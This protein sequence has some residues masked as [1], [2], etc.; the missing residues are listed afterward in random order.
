MG[1]TPSMKGTNQMVF[2]GRRP[3]EAG[4]S[5]SGE[6]GETQRARDAIGARRER[7]AG[8]ADDAAPQRAACA[9]STRFPGSTGRTYRRPSD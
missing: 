1:K 3:L 7:E 2:R 6:G 4:R 5:P 9:H 8:V